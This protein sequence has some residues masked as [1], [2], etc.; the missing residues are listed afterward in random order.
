MVVLLHHGLIVIP[1]LSHPIYGDT[2]VGSWGWLLYSP[3]HLFWAGSEAVIVFFVLSGF[4][5][6]LPV[7]RAERFDWTAYYGSRLIRL[8][9]PVFASLIW[10]F[11]LATLIPRDLANAPSLWLRA[12]SASASFYTV[13]HDAVLVNGPST[14]N[15]PLWSL[16]YEVFF[17]L[18]LPI[19]YAFGRRVAPFWGYA[20]GAL[21][22]LVG[23]A[24]IS[25]VSAVRYLLVFGIGVLLAVRIDAV[26]RITERINAARLGSVFWCIILGLAALSITAPWTVCAAPVAADRRSA[27]RSGG[28]RGRADHFRRAR[29]PVVLPLPVYGADRLAGHHFVQPVPVP[30]ADRDRHRPAAPGA[31][32]GLHGADQ[33]PGVAGFRLPVLSARRTAVASRIAGRSAPARR[34]NPRHPGPRHGL[35]PRRIRTRHVRPCHVCTYHYR[36]RH[37]CRTTHSHCK[38]ACR[39]TSTGGPSAGRRTSEPCWSPCGARCRAAERRHPGLGGGYATGIGARTVNR[40]AAASVLVTARPTSTAAGQHPSDSAVMALGQAIASGSF[41]L[42]STDLFDTI[43]LRDHS[44]ESVRLQAA[45]V[46]SAQ[47]L[48]VPAAALTRLRWDAHTMAYRAVAIERPAGEATLSGMWAAVAEV[49]GLEAGAA[50]LLAED[51]VDVDVEHLR[52]NDDLLAVL[53]AAV[54]AGVKVIA[55]SDTYYSGQH[56]RRMISAVAGTDPFCRVYS[57]ADLGLTKH[58][59]RI[60]AEVGRREGVQA[61]RIVHIGDD[62]RADVEMAAAAGWTPIQLSGTARARVARLAGKGLSVPTRRRRER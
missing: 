15:G 20:V 14:L 48:G 16:K 36:P 5:L 6:T 18:L 26:E 43:L 4:V 49:L 61:G 50:Q 35:A 34:P 23:L 3:L 10:A 41:D 55:V 17:S 39:R 53:A 27:S 38:P 1:D 29:L 59:G 12:H 19:Y 30:R 28:A 11:T 21:V 2:D 22:I 7:L 33:Y 60:F 58:G 37:D 47:R 57:S 32:A 56:L 31:G 46:R 9:L 13:L 42:V 51:E 40:P 54:G 24:A 25:P 45:C 62:R 52:P 8:Y 44:T